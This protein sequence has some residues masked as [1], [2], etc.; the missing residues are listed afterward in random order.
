MIRSAAPR[1]DA[2]R[3]SAVRSEQMPSGWHRRQA[4]TLADGREDRQTLA[5][6]RFLRET[7]APA[8][9]K[10]SSLPRAGLL[11]LAL[12]ELVRAVW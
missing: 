1:T 8:A 5:P 7:R 9:A 11:S 10:S 2:F 3:A 12:A 4:P 6:S